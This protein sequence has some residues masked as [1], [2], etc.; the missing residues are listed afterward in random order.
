MVQDRD[1]WLGL[2]VGL[3]VREFVAQFNVDLVKH[4]TNVIGTEADRK[5]LFE[6]PQAESR[7]A[8]RIISI[9]VRA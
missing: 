1:N 8:P 5:G 7:A 6:S 2:K 4:G 9:N 3:P